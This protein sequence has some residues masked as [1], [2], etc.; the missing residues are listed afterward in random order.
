MLEVNNLMFDIIIV[1]G[2]TMWKW[3]NEDPTG[4]MFFS[5]LKVFV[6]MIIM[7]FVADGANVFSVSV[8]ELQTWL[9][10]ALGALL[11]T[12]ANWLNPSDVRYGRGKVE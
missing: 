7:L 5:W 9:A 10:V 2:G 11:P 3:L 1:E 6:A 8:T 12:V 4:S